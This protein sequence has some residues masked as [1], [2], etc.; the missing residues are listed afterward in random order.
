MGCFHFR[1]GELRNREQI[2]HFSASRAYMMMITELISSSSY[3]CALYGVTDDLLTIHG[4]KEI[5]EVAKT[6]V[7]RLLPPRSSSRC[8]SASA[9]AA[10]ERCRHHMTTSLQGGTSQPAVQKLK[11]IH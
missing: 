1:E 2:M 10:K 3:I 5:P 8:R 11:L 6:P 4:E 9:R 7:N